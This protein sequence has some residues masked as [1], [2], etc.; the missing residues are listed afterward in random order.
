MEIING[1]DVYEDYYYDEETGARV[2]NMNDF[3]QDADNSNVA[4]HTTPVTR[5]T[6]RT[7]DSRGVGC[8][9][10]SYLDAVVGRLLKKRAR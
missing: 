6:P 8:A 2:S 9:L 4:S 3:V 7:S 10:R 1:Y 5:N